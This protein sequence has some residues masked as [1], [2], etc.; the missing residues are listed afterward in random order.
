MAHNGSR[1]EGISMAWGLRPK[2][3]R[4]LIDS[5]KEVLPAYVEILRREG[6]AGAER[7]A[8]L[9]FFGFIHYAIAYELNG[10]KSNKTT[11]SPFSTLPPSVLAL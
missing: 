2:A 8:V 4:K 9:T 7:E 1:R 5:G 6:L 11:Y 3:A 10:G